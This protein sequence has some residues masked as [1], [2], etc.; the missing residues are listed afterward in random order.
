MSRL[1]LRP[2]GWARTA[3][4][5][6]LDRRGANLGQPPSRKLKTVGG[7]LKPLDECNEA[8]RSW[9]SGMINA[10]NGLMRDRYS[11]GAVAFVHLLRS[12]RDAG[13]FD[14]VTA[15]VTQHLCD[16]L[17]DDEDESY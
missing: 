14:Q 1:D 13:L 4:L 11:E 2:G 15:L 5:A 3:I 16:R 12:A 9:L 10:G 7:N 8:V 17:E 6:L